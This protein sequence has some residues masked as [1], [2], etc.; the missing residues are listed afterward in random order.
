MYFRLNEDVPV[1]K[2]TITAEGDFSQPSSQHHSFAEVFLVSLI[3][4]VMWANRQDFEINQASERVKNNFRAKWTVN[5]P[6]Y[7]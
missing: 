3:I 1:K 7:S 6:L 4:N 5:L 2:A